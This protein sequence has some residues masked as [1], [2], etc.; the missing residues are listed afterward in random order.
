MWKLAPPLATLALL[1]GGCNDA[2]SNGTT[3]APTTLPAK[4][5]VPAAVARACRQ[6]ARTTP[7]IVVQCP[8]FVPRP[9]PRLS[10]KYPHL[11]KLRAT[12]ANTANRRWYDLWL[13]YGTPSGERHQT[14]G[15]RRF[16]HFELAAGDGGIV[17]SQMGLRGSRRLGAATIGGHDGTLYHQ[18]PF[19]LGGQWGDHYFF[20]WSQNGLNY[21]ASVHSW[22]N[23]PAAV[24]LLGNVIASLKPV[25]LIT[26]S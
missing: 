9:A 26:A 21:Y 7:G 20:K 12:V 8:T 3:T 14:Y 19:P 17:A 4:I 22:G 15:P 25:A 11:Y 18:E 24:D 5:S 23:R 1:L 10:A 13:M 6:A 2:A 16:L